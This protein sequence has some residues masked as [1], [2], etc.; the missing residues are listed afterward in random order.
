VRDVIELVLVHHSVEDSARLRLK[1]NNQ[2]NLKEKENN[3]T[4]L[5]N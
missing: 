2:E 3:T 1:K 4:E 5:C